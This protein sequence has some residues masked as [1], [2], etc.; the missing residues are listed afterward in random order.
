[1]QPVL[2]S[3]SRTRTFDVAVVGAGIVGMATAMDLAK[4]RGMSVVVVEAEE[5]VAAHQTGNNSGVIHAGLYYKPGSLKARL[6]VEGR[7]ELY[8]FCSEHG[9]P[10]EQCGKVVVATIAEEIPA[11]EELER[12]A[13]ANGVEGVR[14]ISIEELTELEPHVRG[15]AALHSPVTGIVDYKA[16]TRAMAD[17]VRANGGDVRLRSALTGVSHRGTEIVLETTRGAVRAN[18]LVNCAGLHSDRVA[19]L[20]GIDPDV[21]IIPFRGEYYELAPRAVGLVRNLVYPVPDARF[22][23]LGVHFTRMIHGGVEAGPNAVLAL[24]RHGYRWA[25]VEPRDLFDTLSW[26][27]FWNMARQYWRMGL[28]E[29]H[30]SLSKS[31]FVTALQKLLPELES[32]DLVPGS[33]GVRAQA[34]DVSGKLLDDFRIIR[35]NNEIHVLNSPSPA[36]TASIAIGRTIAGAVANDS[37][38]P[39]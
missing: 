2:S 20:C 7:R 38:L 12:R 35:K 24:A 37:A 17:V 18:H 25:D 30:R 9:V 10:H 26:P 4:E 34:V 21:R 13:V 15:M 31:A 33:S 19:R 39:V 3:G 11:L 23:F 36:A 29:F 22:P 14:R 5:N 6:S 27:G 32:D 28:G 16:M 8:A 1:M